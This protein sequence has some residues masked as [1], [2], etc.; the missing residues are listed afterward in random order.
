MKFL[1]RL[2]GFWNK[3][4][5]VGFK[6]FKA[7]LVIFGAAV[8]LFLGHQLDV[9]ADDGLRCIFAVESEANKI[10]NMDPWEGGAYA[11]FTVEL[12]GDSYTRSYPVKST[13]SRGNFELNTEENFPG[14]SVSSCKL[15]V[16]DDYD[17][18]VG[19][20]VWFTF[21]GKDLSYISLGGTVTVAGSTPDSLC[22][23]KKPTVTIKD[24]E[25]GNVTNEFDINKD[26][27]FIGEGRTMSETP[28]YELD[29]LNI[30]PK[31]GSIRAGGLRLTK[32]GSG[33]TYNSGSGAVTIDNYD[34]GNIEFTYGDVV[35]FT[36]A[37]Q[38][39]GQSPWTNLLF[40]QSYDCA[41]QT[42]LSSIGGIVVPSADYSKGAWEMLYDESSVSGESFEA[43]FKVSSHDNFEF[44]AASVSAGSSGV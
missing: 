10:I 23:A 32:G 41:A 19:M 42:D 33:F 3:F 44:E 14:S 2:F 43:E 35:Y 5:N 36:S 25:G 6:Y 15:K 11:P 9:S 39:Q 8:A 16:S 38:G 21:D 20:G 7:S 17:A 22:V 40:S 4:K 29:T 31:S 12:K 26:V 34:G 13:G 30:K 27:T 18:L 28:R 1:E 37:T 24:A